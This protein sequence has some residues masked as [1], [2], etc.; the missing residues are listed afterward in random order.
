MIILKFH[1]L[2]F[3]KQFSGNFSTFLVIAIQVL[4][5]HEILSEVERAYY[6]LIDLCPFQ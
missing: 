2:L 1:E 5:S 3:R 6:Q 4:F